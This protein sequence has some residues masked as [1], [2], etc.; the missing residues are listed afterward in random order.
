VT[1]QTKT[2]FGTN[3]VISGNYCVAHAARLARVDVVA[4]YPI[5]PQTSIVEKI[6]DFIAAGEMKTRFIPVESEMSALYATAGAAT[7]GIRAFTATARQGLVYMHEMIHWVGRGMLPIVMAVVD[8]GI[9]A[10]SPLG[11]EQDASLSQR[12]TGWMQ[13]YCETNQE[14]LDTVLQ[15]YRV[16]EQV[17]LPA[18]VCLDGFFLS[19]TSEPV[20]IPD[21]EM[22]DRYLPKKMMKGRVTPDNP[23]RIFGAGG[24]PAGTAFSAQF[25][26][27]AYEAM[28]AAKQ[29]VKTADEEF[30]QLFDRSYGVV[31]CY[32]TDDAEVILVVSSTITSIAR[33]VIDMLRQQGRKV[34]LLKIRMF[35][36]FP[37]KEVAAALSNAR[38]VAVIDR[39][40]SPGRGGIFATEVKAAMYGERS[41]PPVFGFVTGLC[42]LAVTP[43]LLAEI[44]DYTYQHDEPEGDVIWRG[45]PEL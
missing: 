17:S 18:M 30:K 20:C 26:R 1:L 25:R 15:A 31:E 42:G 32:R 3:K 43:E 14:V 35:R 19:H 16:A 40:I 44:I 24:G 28:E 45:V 23:I 22:V 4:A 37:T 29:V 41:K 6:V 10:P 36:P 21:I 5:T 39:N 7:T 8:S 33:S 11:A 9:G 27:R 38:K 13:F 12:D 2:K 34:G